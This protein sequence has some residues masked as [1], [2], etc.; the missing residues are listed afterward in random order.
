MSFY[1]LIYSGRGEIV[2]KWSR[3]L[4]DRYSKD[5]MVANNCHIDSY[6]KTSR[7]RNM[8]IS[9][10]VRD[11]EN[12]FHFVHSLSNFPHSAQSI[13]KAIGS[14]FQTFP[15]FLWLFSFIFLNSFRK[16]AWIINAMNKQQLSINEHH[17]PNYPFSAI[18]LRKLRWNWISSK[19]IKSFY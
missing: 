1:C 10:L 5:A 7:K 2:K 15:P 16:L 6:K 17:R 13:N 9:F 12:D 19:A 8:K 14:R 11:I 18:H 4:S 3:L